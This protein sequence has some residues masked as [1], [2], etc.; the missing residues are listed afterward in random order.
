MRCHEKGIRGSLW[1]KSGR[2]DSL[3]GSRRNWESLTKFRGA[4]KEMKKKCPKVEK[5]TGRSNTLLKPG[6]QESD[7]CVVTYVYSFIFFLII[8]KKTVTLPIFYV[9]KFVSDSRQNFTLE[10]PLGVN[11]SPVTSF[12]HD[13]RNRSHFSDLGLW[14]KVYTIF[15][16]LEL[17]WLS[18]FMSLFLLYCVQGSMSKNIVISLIREFSK[19]VSLLLL[20]AIFRVHIIITISPSRGRCLLLSPRQPPEASDNHG[21]SHPISSRRAWKTKKYYCNICRDTDCVTSPIDIGFEPRHFCQA[22]VLY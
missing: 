2:G 6:T 14:Y 21:L 10:T 3:W 12:E 9:S 11:F 19:V 8:R 4:K 15:T 18:A 1:K 13:W 7:Y 5:G 16:S 22:I 17:P 20:S